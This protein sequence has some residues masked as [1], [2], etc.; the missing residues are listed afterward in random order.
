[1]RCTMFW[2][3]SD[4]CVGPGS[5]PG[6]YEVGRFER[7]AGVYCTKYVLLKSATVTSA[8]I[9]TRVPHTMSKARPIFFTLS[10]T[11]TAWLQITRLMNHQDNVPFDE[12]VP[13]C[14]SG[15]IL[16]SLDAD[17]H[18]KPCPELKGSTQQKLIAPLLSPS[19]AGS[20][21]YFQIV[22]RND[23]FSTSEPNRCPQPRNALMGVIIPVCNQAS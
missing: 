14:K 11:M 7:H 9:C 15:S 20:P 3:S 12:A 18:Y 10:L 17:L 16:T 5:P 13:Q 1:M 22:H 21:L 23:T 8:I 2:V 19:Q 4:S 6:S